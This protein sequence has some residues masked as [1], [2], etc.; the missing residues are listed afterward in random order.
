MFHFLP[1]FYYI[2]KNFSAYFWCRKFGFAKC[3]VDVNSYNSAA[4]ANGI[5]PS[6]VWDG[7]E[8]TEGES[9]NNVSF[10]VKL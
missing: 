9:Q 6:S 1:A 2:L 3:V 7:R 10:T 5:D 4:V 8:E